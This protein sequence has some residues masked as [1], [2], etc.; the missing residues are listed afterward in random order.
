MLRKKHSTQELEK[1]DFADFRKSLARIR[2]ENSLSTF[3][4]RLIPIFIIVSVIAHALTK[5]LKVP[6]NS[7]WIIW[8][9][10]TLF[11]VNSFVYKSKERNVVEEREWQEAFAGRT[12]L[13]LNLEIEAYLISPNESKTAAEAR[14]LAALQS[15]RAAGYTSLPLKKKLWVLKRITTTKKEWVLT[16]LSVAERYGGEEV[17]EYVEKLTTAH[18]LANSDYEVHNAA[19]EAL[20][21]IYARL[22]AAK[23]GEEML[24][25]SEAPTPPDTLLRPVTSQTSPEEPLQLLRPSSSSG[26]E[27]SDNRL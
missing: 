2:R 9:F 17:L 23:R 27:P 21:T 14:L 12:D 7:S 8:Q 24:R 10:A 11:I 5:L 22:R 4:I 25:P 16:V 3:L 15:D 1:D 18:W 20:P 26:E 13:P 19:R 6:N